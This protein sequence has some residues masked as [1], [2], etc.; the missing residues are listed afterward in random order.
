[1]ERF[2]RSSRTEVLNSWLFACL[3]EA[4]EIRHRWLQSFNEERPCV[5][6]GS[7]SPAVFR[8]RL[9]TENRS[10]SIYQHRPSRY[11]WMKWILGW[12]SFL[13]LQILLHI[14]I[15]NLYT[16]RIERRHGGLSRRRSF[17][18]KG[19]FIFLHRL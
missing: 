14:C 5:A 6:L 1:I 10:L 18:F 12:L 17:S 9:L 2:N 8:E 16:Y 19:L 15:K 3:D 11:G 4:R 7:L 13:L